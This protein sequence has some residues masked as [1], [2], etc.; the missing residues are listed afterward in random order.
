M[1]S[2]FVER[3]PCFPAAIFILPDFAPYPVNAIN[4]ASDGD[5]Y[6]A[7]TFEMDSGDFFI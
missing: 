1:L 4:L 5:N 6:G 7:W 2:S 3:F